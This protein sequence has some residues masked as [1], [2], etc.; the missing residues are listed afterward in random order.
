M[1]AA[2]NFR[3]VREEEEVRAANR[4]RKRTKIADVVGEIIERH[5]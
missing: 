4:K 2:E 5:C 3:K 1:S